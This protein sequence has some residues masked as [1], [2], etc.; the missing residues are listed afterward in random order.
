MPFF[1]YIPLI[2]NLF[3]STEKQRE[4]VDLM[5]FLTP[6]IIETPEHASQVTDRIIRDGQELS[7]AERILIQRNN[8]DY[9]K[10]TRKEGVT[11]EMLDPKGLIY[12]PQPGDEAEQSAPAA[13]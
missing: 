2:G 8:S 7:E 10:A 9:Q 4:K 5:I 12:A 11:R 1:S 6:Y 13:K 3:K